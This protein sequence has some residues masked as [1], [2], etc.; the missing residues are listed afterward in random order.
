MGAWVRGV[1]WG[2]GAEMLAEEMGTLD[3]IL[4]NFYGFREKKE[5]AIVD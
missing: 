3:D 2:V 5:L 4:M 1:F